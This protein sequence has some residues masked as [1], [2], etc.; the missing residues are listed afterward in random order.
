[1]RIATFNL[2]NLDDPVAPRAGVLRPALQRL[3]ADILCLQEVNGQ[4]EAGQKTRTLAAL[5]ELLAGT[6]YEGY[7]RTATVSRS[8]RH[9]PSDVH[10]LVTLSRFPVRAQRQLLHDLLPPVEVAMLA[11]DPPNA[12]K[13][14]IRFERPVLVTEVEIGSATLTVINVHFRAPIASA[15]PGQKSGPYSWKRVDAWAEGYY[16]SGIKRIGQ[17]LEVRRL[18]DQIFDADPDAMVLVTGDFNAEIQE[19]TVRLLKG[20]SEDTGNGDLAYRSLVVLDRAIEASRRYSVVHHGRPQMLDHM[21]ASHALYGRFHTIEVHNEA[22]GDE[23]I[24]WAKA[25]G[26]AG[27]YHAGVVATFT[28]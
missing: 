16:L 19:T 21:L 24:A 12:D 28:D 22:L 8:R 5:D 25:V 2:E 15:I 26:V 4:Q 23:A 7:H 1:M 20:G 10:N 3:D 11:S 6:R 27:S 9:G 13:V 14:P 17:A 18:V